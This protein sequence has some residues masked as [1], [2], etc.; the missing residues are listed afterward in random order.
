MFEEAIAAAHGGPLSM[1]KHSFEG[2]GAA[3]PSATWERG[4]KR[5]VEALGTSA[6]AM[7]HPAVPR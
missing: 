3:F 7:T 2:K 1:T 5:G 4:L 6:S